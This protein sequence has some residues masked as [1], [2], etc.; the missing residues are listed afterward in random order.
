MSYSTSC[1]HANDV[2]VSFLELNKA[3]HAKRSILFLYDVVNLFN[4]F[5]LFLPCMLMKS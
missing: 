5:A 3:K 2:H 1:T 4:L